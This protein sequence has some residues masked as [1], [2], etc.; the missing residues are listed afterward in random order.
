MKEIAY[1]LGR[2]VLVMQPDEIL[3]FRSF[4]APEAFAAIAKRYSFQSTP[5]LSVPLER[6]QKDGLRFR[7]G[8]VPSRD[9]KE[10]ATVT[11]FIV[12]S[13][14]FVVDSS[15]TDEAE[16]FL[17][18]LMKW[19]KEALG[20]RDFQRPPRQVYLSQVTVEFES[21]ANKIIHKFDDI[22]T[23]FTSLLMKTYRM[24]ALVEVQ[25]V[26]F[27]YDRLA[28]STL[29]NLVQFVIERKVGH[30]YEDGCFWCQAPLR[31][32]DHLH[33]LRTLEKLLS[34]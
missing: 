7:V 12:F 29:Y 13:D 2:V 28:A 15:N 24:N 6:I 10:S 31:T 23:L 4:Y 17:A 27:D 22:A 19:G 21:S 18:D 30:K 34:K 26:R 1:D 5:D 33:A 16:I 11:D 8:R 20:L 3:P 9:G 25:G 32:T 14:G